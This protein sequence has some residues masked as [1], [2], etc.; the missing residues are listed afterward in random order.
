MAHEHHQE[1]IQA[2]HD[3]SLHCNICFDECLNDT[4]HLDMLSNAIRLAR[5]C[6]DTCAFT[7]QAVAR[8][9][10]FHVR[11]AGY[12]AEVC[13]TCA[14]ECE[15]HGHHDHCMRCAEACRRCAEAC[16]TIA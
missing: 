2:L 16:R 4:E 13:D 6:A 14:D 11:L 10:Q 8:N 7:E 15:K 12:C 1:L 5:D 3:C 9:S